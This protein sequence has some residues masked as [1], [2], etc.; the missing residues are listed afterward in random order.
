[1]SAIIDKALDNEDHANARHLNHHFLH[2]VEEL[3]SNSKNNPHIE[4]ILLI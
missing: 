1:M 4:D 3:Q 2:E